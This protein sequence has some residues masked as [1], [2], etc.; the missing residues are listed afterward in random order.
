MSTSNKLKIQVTRLSQ[1]IFNTPVITGY[2]GVQ[3]IDS[4]FRIP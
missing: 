1:P 2:W 4:V 3:T